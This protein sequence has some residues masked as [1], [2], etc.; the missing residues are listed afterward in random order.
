MAVLGGI[1]I[2][3]M[4]CGTHAVQ[5]PNVLFL[6]TDDQDIMLGSMDLDGPLKKTRDLIVNKGA[7]FTNAF[8]NT[9]ICCPSRAEIQTGR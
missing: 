6:L 4:A 2:M 1:I 9:P 8:A 3:M 7:Y 5:K